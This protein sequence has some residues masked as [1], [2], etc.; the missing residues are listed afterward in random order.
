MNSTLIGRFNGRVVAFGLAVFSLVVFFVSQVVLTI[1][2]TDLLAVRNG[3]MFIRMDRDNWQG[4]N[5]WFWVV[6]IVSL[7]CCIISKRHISANSEQ[8]EKKHLQIF[9]LE[10]A[11]VL[12]I[13]ALIF[14]GVLT[15]TPPLRT[16][17]D[18]TL[19]AKRSW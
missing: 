3:W 7:V 1:A 10:Y 12:G 8:N 11:I 19:L 6:F 16:F 14:I 4:I 5:F 13:C 17:Y 9:R 2:P 18:L 15:D